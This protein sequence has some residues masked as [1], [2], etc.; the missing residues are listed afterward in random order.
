M[1][2]RERRAYHKVHFGSDDIV[3]NGITLN[4]VHIIPDVFA[5]G[6]SIDYYI[7]NGKDIGL[8]T[9]LNS[10]KNILTLIPGDDI[11]Y[12]IA[13]FPIVDA[14]SALDYITHILSSLE[15]PVEKT[16]ISLDRFYPAGFAKSGA[17]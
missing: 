5:E 14:D 6:Q 15:Q 9:I 13:E 3:K 2:A 10:P 7:D 1:N 17:V 11:T 12:I 16:V 4:N 8:L